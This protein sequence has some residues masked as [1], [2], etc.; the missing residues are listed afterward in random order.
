MVPVLKIMDT[1][2]SDTVPNKVNEL[3]GDTFKIL[4]HTIV[5][6]NELR[7]EKLKQ[8]L[9]PEYWSL[10]SNKP[11][12]TKL[13]GDKLAEDI[14]ALKESKSNLTSTAMTTKKP[15]LFKLGRGE[16]Q[17]P[18]FPT[19]ALP[20]RNTFASCPTQQEPNDAYDKSL[21]K[22]SNNQTTQDDSEVI[23]VSS[24]IHIKLNNTVQNFR[25]GKTGDNIA[26]WE[27]MTPDQWILNSIKGY[28]V[29]IT[30]TPKQVRVPA[31]FAFSANERKLIA[32]E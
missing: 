22:P 16:Q 28:S 5:Q 6:S 23:F 11:S 2:K 31:P 1:I 13:F 20:G 19:S 25:A 30:N 15:F 10:C 32:S 7:T 14:E 9:L 27:T 21:S 29:E 8:D 26:I 4:A 12:A 17:L 18:K 3:A 24:D